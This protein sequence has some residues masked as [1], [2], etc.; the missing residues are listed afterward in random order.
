MVVL[1]GWPAL[2]V[3]VNRPVAPCV[4]VRVLGTRLVSVT[5]DGLTCT[6]LRAERPLAVATIRVWPV[7]RAVTGM[8]TVNCPMAKGIDAGTL[9]TLGF[10]LVT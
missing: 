1:I 5:P 7:C 6:V 8:V 2:I 9:A 3:T 10:L 4:M